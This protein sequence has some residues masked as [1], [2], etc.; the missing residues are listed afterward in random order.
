MKTAQ[1]CPTHGGCAYSQR[2]DA[3]YCAECNEWSED[4]CGEPACQYCGGRP[5]TPCSLVIPNTFIA[6]GE[7]GNYC[8]AECLKRGES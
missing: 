1:V 8:S 7:G 4:Q 6:C 2:Y 5:E 3:Y